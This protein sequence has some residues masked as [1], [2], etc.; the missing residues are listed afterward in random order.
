M[1][2]LANWSYASAL[3][4][5][6]M[7]IMEALA[8]A[9]D[10]EVLDRP[11]D[12][13]LVELYELWLEKRGSRLMPSRRNFDPSEFARLLPYVELY[14]VGP[15]EGMYKVRLVGTAIVEL[16][17]RDNTGKPAGYGLPEAT[18]HTIAEVLNVVTRRRAPLFG[19]GRILWLPGKDHRRF[20]ACA[21]PLSDDDSTVNIILCALKLQ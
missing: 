4:P 19:R 21:L 20:E 6:G 10:R 14:D 1:A 3:L 2:M 7:W 5:T 12:R 16:A 17:G 8:R 9:S 18:A 11:T 13:D 15:A